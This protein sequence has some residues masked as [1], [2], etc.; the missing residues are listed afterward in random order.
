MATIHGLLRSIAGIGGAMLLTCLQ[1]TMEM[2]QP[3]PLEL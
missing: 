3:V 1:L 2:F